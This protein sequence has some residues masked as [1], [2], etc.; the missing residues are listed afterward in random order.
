MPRRFPV[1]ALI[2]YHNEIY[3]IIYVHPHNEEFCQ[4][5]RDKAFRYVRMQVRTVC[6]PLVHTPRCENGGNSYVFKN[7]LTKTGRNPCINHA[8]ATSKIFL[9]VPNNKFNGVKSVCNILFTL[10]LNSISTS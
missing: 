2:L 9:L 10:N 5:L 6:T 7:T 4:S 1:M 8:T 3:D